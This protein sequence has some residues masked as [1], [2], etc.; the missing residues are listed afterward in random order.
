MTSTDGMRETLEAAPSR[1]KLASRCEA[2]MKGCEK[3][4]KSGPNEGDMWFFELYHHLREAADQLRSQ[5]LENCDADSLANQPAAVPQQLSE[6]DITMVAH[7][8]DPEAFEDEPDPSTPTER[9]LWNERNPARRSKARGQACRIIKRLKFRWMTGR[10]TIIE[11]CARAAEE[12]ATSASLYENVD[13]ARG[14]TA[15]K[16]EIAALIR[17]LS[18]QSSTDSRET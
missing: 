10:A 5:G 12:M 8:I 18:P 9:E 16:H 15:A 13:K 2:L 7:V 6:D 1:E 11:E 3:L 14:A 4:Y 17:S